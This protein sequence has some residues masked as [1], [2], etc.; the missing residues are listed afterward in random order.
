M[1]LR[2]YRYFFPI[3]LSWHWYGNKMRRRTAEGRIIYR[4]PTAAEIADM[5]EYQDNKAW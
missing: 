5:E 2:L 4:A 3:S 1:L